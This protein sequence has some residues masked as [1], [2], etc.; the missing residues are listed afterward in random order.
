MVA[1][2]LVC[3]YYLSLSSISPGNI[4]LSS[5]KISAKATAEITPDNSF[6]HL[7]EHYVV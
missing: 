5:D 7:A 4:S 6:T 1:S 2:R 3:S